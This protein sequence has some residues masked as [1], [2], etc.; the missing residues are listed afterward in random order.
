MFYTP[1]QIFNL[2][3]QCMSLLRDTLANGL[4]PLTCN[5]YA[6]DTYSDL[7]KH[8][9]TD[10][11]ND[12][13]NNAYGC[14]KQLYILKKHNRNLKVLLSIG[15]WTYSTN[16]AAA[17]STA[18]T[19]AQFANTAVTL[20]KDWGF[21]GID[22][23][24]E[25]PA[26]NTEAANFVL[27]LRAVRNAMD[28]YA[29]QHAPGYHFLITVASPAGPSHYDVLHMSAMDAYLDAWHLMAFDYTGSWDTT[30]GHQANLYPSTSNPA[31]TP[32]STDRAVKDYIAAGVPASKI[33]LG[34]PVYGRSF[35]STSGLGQ[36]FSG[37]GSGT[38]EAGVWDY[39]AL[40]LAGA[41]VYYDSEAGA[42]YSY[43]ASS[44]E[45]ISYD[46]VISVT[47][48][49]KYVQKN[50]MGGAMFWE[51][52][53]DG[54]GSKSLISTAV[55]TLGV[56]AQQSNLLGYPNSQYANIAAGMPNE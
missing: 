21:D 33:V 35:E 29:A 47:L 23:D 5:R 16:F 48:K 51:T 13:G 32:F 3:A 31:S 44:R 52:S 4:R 20:M 53:A 25:Y 17:A 39:K 27:L 26:S 49:S 1:L 38:W 28:T 56:L 10:S 50:G 45:L 15:G 8:Y 42:S 54:S 19:R 40:P 41:K 12:I 9:P 30:S 36:P 55:G 37:V 22:I 2:M 6:S 11:W 18:T 46:T 43:D 34:M 24:W 7:Q 14:V